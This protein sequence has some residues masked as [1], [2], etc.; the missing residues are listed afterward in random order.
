MVQFVQSQ[1]ARKLFPHPLGSACEAIP[2]ACFVR[3]DDAEI[4]CRIPGPVLRDVETNT[5]YVGCKVERDSVDLLE[6]G[7]WQS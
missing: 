4:D 5:D 7:E 6:W 1:V 2:P 3:E